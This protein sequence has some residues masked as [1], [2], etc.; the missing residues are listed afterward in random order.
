MTPQLPPPDTEAQSHSDALRQYI[1]H[2]IRQQG[3]C[4]P[5]K[6]FMELA[7]YAP[8]LGYYSAGSHKL[9]EAGDFITAPELS[10]FFGATL[11]QAIMPVLQTLPQANIL[12]IGAGSGALA[13]SILLSL[14][15]QGHELEHYYILEVSADLRERQRQRLQQA[16]LLESVVWLETLPE[17]FVGVVLGNEV[18]DAMP[19]HL[20][21]IT[22]TGLKERYVGMQHDEFIWQ[23]RPASDTR[24]V[25]RLG[26]IEQQ[27][28]V[29]LAAGFVSEINL[30][31]EDWL[32]AL[33]AACKQ[34]YVL[35]IDYGFPRHEYYHPQ[36]WQGTLMCHYRHHSHD[37][38]FR[39]I[40]LQDITA[41]I[42][43]TA[44]ADAALASGWTVAGYTTQAHFLLG[45]G[46]MTCLQGDTSVSTVEQ[47]KRQQ[48]VKKLT[49]PHEMGEL[50]KVIGLQKN[51]DVELPG[52]VLRD[53]RDRL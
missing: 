35:L 49:L 17:N 47:L 10:P 42:D 5:F 23:L 6:R 1:S 31:A 53:L 28:S 51:L 50:F 43:F 27:L 11:A 46:L 3:G 2:K 36:R 13:V 41:H 30:A 12:E 45:S 38:P 20:V 33:L 16:G 48:Q 7:L 37:D 8:G 14:L 21:E 19:V 26:E 4:I 32:A 24:L 29:T 40:G 22:E 39:F 25:Q 15:Q 9:G 18:L 52:F 44:I 34:A